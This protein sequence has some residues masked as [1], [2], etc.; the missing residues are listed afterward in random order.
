MYNHLVG[1][2]CHFLRSLLSQAQASLPLESRYSGSAWHRAVDA[3][4]ARGF[5][6][7][8]MATSR[9]PSAAPVR[10]WAALTRPRHTTELHG[11]PAKAQRP[12][13]RP[14]L[15]ISPQA[16]TVGSEHFQAGSFRY[17]QTAIDRSLPSCHEC[18][19]LR[20][21]QNSSQCQKS[22]PHQN[23]QRWVRSPHSRTAH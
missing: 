14:S 21:G 19:N 17:S 1:R 23:H 7:A 5:T 16:T 6:P 18:T 11:L 20:R 3:F 9:I 13:A 22:H 8:L 4:A 10:A 12:T 2:D 15:H